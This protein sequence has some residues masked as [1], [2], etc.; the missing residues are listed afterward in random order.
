LLLGLNFKITDQNYIYFLR[1][2]DLYVFPKLPLLLAGRQY[3]GISSV[4]CLKSSHSLSQRCT[5]EQCNIS[6]TTLNTS[7]LI[8][9][10]LLLIAKLSL[11][12]TD[13]IAEPCLQSVYNISVCL[14]VCKLYLRHYWRVSEARIGKGSMRKVGWGCLRIGYW[15]E[16]WF[17]VFWTVH[18]Q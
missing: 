2:L 5:P 9:L 15:G 8:K 10:I 12:V 11:N 7:T 6:I 4:P 18:F 16:F 13:V 1:L 3:F 17:F 14:S